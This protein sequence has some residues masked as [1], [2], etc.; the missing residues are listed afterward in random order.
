MKKQ[1]RTFALRS[2]LDHT[3]Q[4]ERCTMMQELHYGEPI[5]GEQPLQ[6]YLAPLQQITPAIQDLIQDALYGLL[7]KRYRISLFGSETTHG[8]MH[9]HLQITHEPTG[10]SL[11]HHERIN[12]DFI[13]DIFVLA[14]QMKT[15]LDKRTTLECMSGDAQVRLLTW[16]SD[17]VN[18][19]LL[20]ASRRAQ[21][22]CQQA[23]WQMRIMA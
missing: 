20:E 18:P 2:C 5:N 14:T 23:L 7:G 10:I 15:M 8:C 9:Y 19:A 3:A 6:I 12:A 4:F 13:E 1:L 11:E 22:T 16:I 21:R 17:E